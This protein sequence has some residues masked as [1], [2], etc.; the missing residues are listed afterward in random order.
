MVEFYE[1]I[2]PEKKFPGLDELKKPDGGGLTIS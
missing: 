2:R 1:R